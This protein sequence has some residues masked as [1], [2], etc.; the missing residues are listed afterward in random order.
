MA[1]WRCDL[2]VSWRTQLFSLLIHGV[3]VLITLVAP[4]PDGCTPLWLIL[5]TLVVFECI[6]SQKSITSRQ[7]EIRLKAGNLLIWKRQ[8]W[9]LVRQPWITRYGVLLSLQG[10]GSQRR[11]RVWLA[12]DSMSEDEWRELCLIFRHTF[13]SAAGSE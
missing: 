8:E 13:D 7:G 10:A 2:R 4:W 12:S 1:Q 9:K 11:K 6:R 5:L 3:L